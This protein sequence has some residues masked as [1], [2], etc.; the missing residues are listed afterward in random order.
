ME[1]KVKVFCFDGQDVV[2]VGAEAMY[3]KR[4]DRGIFQSI[5]SWEKRI[6]REIR[7]Q[8]ERRAMVERLNNRTK[9]DSQWNSKR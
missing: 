4:V 6:M 1:E 8:E 5:E 3:S 7:S 2:Y 9:E